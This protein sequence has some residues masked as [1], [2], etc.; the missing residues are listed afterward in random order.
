MTEGITYFPTDSSGDKSRP[1][2]GGTLQGDKEKRFS[3]QCEGRTMALCG[4]VPPDPSPEVSAVRGQLAAVF[5]SCLSSSRGSCTGNSV[6]RHAENVSCT[7]G[8]H[9]RHG[10]QGKKQRAKKRLSEER[11]ESSRVQ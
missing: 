2:S 9:Y 6:T 7:Y 3:A 4:S 8:V 5:G 1:A 11:L 10:S